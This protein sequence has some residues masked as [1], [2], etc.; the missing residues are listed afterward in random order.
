[1]SG[2]WAR[3]VETPV[4]YILQI[5]LQSTP[6]YKI[7]SSSTIIHITIVSRYKEPV[8]FLKFYLHQHMPKETTP[9]GTKF[10]SKGIRDS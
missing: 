1:M 9:M 5:L 10:V 4:K 7:I 8:V 3:E 6:Y 2:L